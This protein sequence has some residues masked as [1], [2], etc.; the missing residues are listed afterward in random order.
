MIVVNRRF[1][2]ELPSFCRAKRSV[3]LAARNAQLWLR[4]ATA[5]DIIAYIS[6]SPLEEKVCIDFFSHSI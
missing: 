2:S 5:D 1:Y 6:R 3:A 4:A